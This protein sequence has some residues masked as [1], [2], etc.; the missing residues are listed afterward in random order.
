MVYDLGSKDSIFTS[1]YNMHCLHWCVQY[2][3]KTLE[4]FKK[5]EISSGCP[6]VGIDL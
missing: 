1:G 5:K 4:N 3:F 6:I 2:P